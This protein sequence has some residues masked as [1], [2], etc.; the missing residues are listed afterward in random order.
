M[1]RKKRSLASKAAGGLWW[2]TKGAAKLTWSGAKLAARGA[3]GAAR[4]AV[5]GAGWAYGRVKEKREEAQRAAERKPASR[6]PAKYAALE[7][8]EPVRGELGDF[9]ERLGKE[10]LIIA[11]AG[12]RGSGKSALGFRLLENIRAKGGR[13]CYAAGVPQKVLPEWISSIEKVEQVRNG[14]AVLVDEGAIEFGA[15]ESMSEKNR[16]FTQLMAIARHKDL[17]LLLVTQNTALIDKNVLRLCDAIVFKE[18]SLLQERMERSALQDLYQAASGR[19]E[20][21]PREE[22]KA[23]A[24]VIDNDFEGMVRAGLPSFWSGAVSKSRA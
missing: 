7:V 9:E 5:K 3:A 14:G 18:G 4:G 11:I 2:L 20:K 23:H 8:A 21:L 16:M 13:A 22:R 17:T 10:S 12:R 19:F 24:Y 15:R 6:E 1:A